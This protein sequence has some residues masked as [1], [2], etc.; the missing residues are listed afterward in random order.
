[1]IIQSLPGR[2]HKMC[3][4]IYSNR[5]EYMKLQWLLRVFAENFGKQRKAE[6]TFV[7]NICKVVSRAAYR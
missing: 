2:Y 7:D 1:M 5:Q 6:R 4:A 3:T